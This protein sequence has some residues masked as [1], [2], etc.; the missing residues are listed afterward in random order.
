MCG[1]AVQ[2]YDARTSPE[3]T[4][5]SGQMMLVAHA[6][7]GCVAR[8]GIE[9]PV[10]L[11]VEYME[12]PAGVDVPYPARFS[13]ALT[14]TERGQVLI[15]ERGRISVVHSCQKGRKRNRLP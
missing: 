10:R 6:I 7:V 14:H 11:R 1:T 3:S 12:N 13:W 5:V 4:Q 8:A 2:L 15:S 9:A